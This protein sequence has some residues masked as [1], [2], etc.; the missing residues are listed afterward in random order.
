[1]DT[2]EI[3]NGLPP[4]GKVHLKINNAFHNPTQ[5]HASRSPERC[6]VLLSLVLPPGISN[7]LKDCGP[8]CGVLGEGGVERGFCLF[9]HPHLHLVTPDLFASMIRGPKSQNSTG[10]KS[11]YLDIQPRDPAR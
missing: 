2:L 3:L 7:E 11:V 5:H 9:S 8:L 6:N 4:G 10:C 1:M